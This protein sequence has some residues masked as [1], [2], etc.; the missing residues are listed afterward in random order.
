ME[1][2]NRPRS[3]GFHRYKAKVSQRLCY[4]QKWV[5]SAPGIADIPALLFSLLGTG[6][7]SHAGAEAAAASLASIKR[8]L[9]GR[10][11]VCFVVCG[12]GG[13][14]GGG[15]SPPVLRAAKKAGHLSVAVV[16]LPFRFEGP[17]RMRQARATMLAL[18]EAADVVIGKTPTAGVDWIPASSQNMVLEGVLCLMCSKSVGHEHLS[19][20]CV[21]HLCVS[22]KSWGTTS[23]PCAAIEQD[24]F[25]QHHHNLSMTQAA[26]LAAHMA[27]NVTMGI[28][29][30][31][32][33]P[34]CCLVHRCP[35]YELSVSETFLH[36]CRS[37]VGGMHTADCGHGLLSS[38]R[39]AVCE[40]LQWSYA[41]RTCA[42]KWRQGG[43][44][45][46]NS[47]H[48]GNATPMCFA[49]CHREQADRLDCFEDLHLH[50]CCRMGMLS[51]APQHGIRISRH[52]SWP[53][54]LRAS[55]RA[56]VGCGQGRTI[57][58]AV[59]AALRAPGVGSLH[60][61]SHAPGGMHSSFSA[62]FVFDRFKHDRC[63]QTRYL[64]VSSQRMPGAARRREPSGLSTSS[65]L[66]LGTPSDSLMAPV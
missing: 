43:P 18:H 54:L 15:A 22:S 29:R 58:Q 38:W 47:D 19:V 44:L 49:A 21:C 39:R 5:A 3:N 4:I 17:R 51:V 42:R 37:Q 46:P 10:P 52:C 60:M 62:A 53:Q 55:G 32:Q 41:G 14:T 36:P 59:A 27:L 50:S 9:G 61:V 66:L 24:A 7:D 56:V 40:L 33:V 12:A 28:T 45:N 6:G 63:P 8:V 26:G 23:F 65:G 57:E 30:L 25:L 16:T 13:G 1:P 20:I 2:D 11:G 34:S 48:Q 64:I 31:L 35:S